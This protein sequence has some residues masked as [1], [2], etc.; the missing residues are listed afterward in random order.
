MEFKVYPVFRL[1][2]LIKLKYQMHFYF[3]SM[4]TQNDLSNQCALINII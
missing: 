2:R 1:Y 4:I 3:P